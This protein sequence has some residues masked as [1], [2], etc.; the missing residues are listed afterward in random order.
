ML[1]RRQKKKMGM[2]EKRM[3]ISML[4]RMKRKETEMETKSTMT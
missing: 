2:E 1:E 3:L 4:M